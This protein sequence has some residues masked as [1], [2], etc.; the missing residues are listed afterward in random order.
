MITIRDWIATIPETEKHI[1]FVG[2]HQTVT[3]GFLLTGEGWKDYADWGFHLDMAFDLTSV[4]SRAERKL[5]KTQVNNTENAT[6][7]QVKTTGTTTK[8]S[9]TVTEVDVD[10]SAKTDV[11]TLSKAVQEDGIRLTWKVLRQHTQLPGKLTATLRALGPDGQVKKSDLMVF[12]VEPAVVAEP[13][14]D[15]P[16]SE[17]EAMEERMDEMLSAVAK[18]ELTVRLNTQDVKDLAQQIAVQAQ[19]VDANTQKTQTAADSALEAEKTA[20]GVRDAMKGA[21]DRYPSNN[22]LDRETVTYG[23]GMDQNGNMGQNP[24]YDLALTD[25]IPVAEGEVLSYQRTNPDTGQREYWGFY[26]ICLFDADK[27]VN[28]E[29]N[30][31]T[32]SETGGLHEITIPAGVAYVRLTLHDLSTS[33]DPAIATCS[34]LVPYEP[35]TGVYRLKKEAYDPEAIQETLQAVR[36]V[37][38]QLTDQ[39]KT[40]VRENIGAMSADFTVQGDDQLSMQSTKPVSSRAVMNMYNNGIKPYLLPIPKTSDEG[41]TLKVVSGVWKIV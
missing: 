2:E 30:T 36:F 38:Q 31:F 17:F 11:A 20:V 6:D 35:Y 32:A 14:A 22:R 1:A 24:A 21:F 4:T 15:L 16:Q 19:Q 27:Q 5:E 7:T 23:K 41:K 3:R 39:Q 25:Y 13:A 40:Q 12:E 26:M 33:V 34:E 8:E 9:Y 37:A 10:C 29:A 18:N 28:T